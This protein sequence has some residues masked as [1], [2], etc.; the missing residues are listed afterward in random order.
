MFFFTWPTLLSENFEGQIFSCGEFNSYILRQ[1]LNSISN[2]LGIAFWTEE[3][4]DD[5]TADS[6]ICH[7]YDQRGEG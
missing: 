6:L 5:F 2:C 3:F 7:T 1:F 4:R